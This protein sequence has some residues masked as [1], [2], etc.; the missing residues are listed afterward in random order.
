MHDD[1]SYPGEEMSPTVIA[2]GWKLKIKLKKHETLGASEIDDQTNSCLFIFSSFF[3][4][5]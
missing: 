4:D 2:V 5:G 1:H 3:F